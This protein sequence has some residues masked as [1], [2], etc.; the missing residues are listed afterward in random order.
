MKDWK[1]LFDH[2]SK[3]MKEKLPAHLTYHHP[4]HTFYVLKTAELIAHEEKVSEE[5]ILLLKTAALYHDIGFIKGALEHEGESM[6]MA[7]AELPGFGYSPGE[8]KIILG[9]IDATTIPQKPKTKLQKILADADLEYLGTDN[10]KKI[11][12]TLLEELRHYNPEL[13]RE[14]WNFMQI[15]FLQ[16]HHYHTEYCLKNRKP[17]KD[18]NLKHLIE[19]TEKHGT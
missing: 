16:K 13:T 17:K 9:L 18:L 1:L 6:R 12:D 2:V 5:D 11:G 8:I 19:E 7:A 15:A 4:E 14:K 3:V 10:F